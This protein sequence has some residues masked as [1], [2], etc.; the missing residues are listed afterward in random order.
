MI[1]QVNPKSGEFEKVE[2]LRAA[3]IGSNPAGEPEYESIERTRDELSLHMGYFE[4][5]RMVGALRMTPLGHGLCFVERACDVRPWFPRLT[6]AFDA[7]RLVLDRSHRGG[8]HL[9]NF[10]LLTA[11]W[12]LKNT[13]FTHASA[14]SRER[15]SALYEDIGGLKVV[16]KIAWQQPDGQARTYCL[17]S[18]SLETVCHTI[19]RRYGNEQHLQIA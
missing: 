13:S 19:K 3:H 7:N 2:E 11:D 17:V 8:H 18:L 6:E 15:L 14:L 4:A 16:D 1:R 5:N 10:L 9:R 12:M